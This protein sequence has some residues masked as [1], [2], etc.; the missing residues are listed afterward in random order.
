M[1]R[2]L[3]RLRL[4]GKA[5]SF[6]PDTLDSLKAL[7]LKFEI[8]IFEYLNTKHPTNLDSLFHLAE[9]YTRAGLLE[10]GLAVDLKLV[11]L[12]PDNPTVRYNLACSY[13]LLNY[14][15]ACLT[16]LEIAIELGYND[17]KHMNNDSD[18]DN[19]KSSPHFREL[20]DRLEDLHG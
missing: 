5:L 16:E 19:V 1:Q 9:L 4:N 3:G 10:Q 8:G 14:L 2:F 7:G 18:L 6:H 15:D 17:A 11:R 13:S 20:L 12:A